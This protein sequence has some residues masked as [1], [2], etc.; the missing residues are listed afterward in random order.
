MPFILFKTASI[1][2]AGRP[3]K[4]KSFTAITLNR[5][6]P[7]C[8]QMEFGAAKTTTTGWKTRNGHH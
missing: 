4:F 3:P 1:A 7:S 5:R 2:V 6:D 8:A